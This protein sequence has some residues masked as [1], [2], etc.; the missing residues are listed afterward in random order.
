MKTVEICAGAGGMALGLEQAGFKHVALLEIDS[1]ACATL[2]HNREEWNVIEGDA[3]T[4]SASAYLG[5]DL[6]AGGTPCPP[7]SV[8]GKQLGNLDSRDLFLEAIR[9]ARE[10]DPNAILLENVRG[11]FDRKFDSYRNLIID[12]LKSFGYD[13]FWNIINACH[14]GVPQSRLRSI[15]VA[16]KKHF[17]GYFVWPP[18]NLAPPPTV[19]RILYSAMAKNGWEGAKRWMAKAN[20]IAPTLVGGSQK[21]GGP[22]LGPTRVRLAWEKL[23]VDAKGLSDFPPQKEFQGYPRLTVQMAALIQGFPPEWE[24]IGKKTASYKQVGNAFP[25]PVAKAIGGAIL[26]ALQREIL[27]IFP[28]NRVYPQ[29]TLFSSKCNN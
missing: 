5:V 18:K 10:C 15:L 28:A 27:P 1:N 29:E 4:F 8:A 12:K 14:Y 25:P 23:G 19:G 2:R 22:D 3:K 26:Q 24:F 20:G 13:C 11:L 21:H 16:L 7:F 6:F 17:S 9:L